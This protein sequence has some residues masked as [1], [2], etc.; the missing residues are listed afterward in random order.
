MIFEWDEQK[1]QKNITKHGVSFEEA[2]EIFTMNATIFILDDEAVNGE[3]RWKAIGTVD[4]Y[5]YLLVAH[6]YY[7]EDDEEYIRLISARK[8]STKEVTK[9]L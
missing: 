5:C 4:G 2:K 6:T 3:N 9:W 8:L 1:N 7:D